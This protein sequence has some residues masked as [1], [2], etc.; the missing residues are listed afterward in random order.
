[1]ETI[2]TTGEINVKYKDIKLNSKLNLAIGLVL[3]LNI[4]Q[5]VLQVAYIYYSDNFVYLFACSLFGP[6][7]LIGVFLVICISKLFIS[8]IF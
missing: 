4:I 5:F 7:Q 6:L 2:Y 3:V 1:M 8:I